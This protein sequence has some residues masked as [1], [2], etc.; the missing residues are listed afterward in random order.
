MSGEGIP[1]LQI[2][3]FFHAFYLMTFAM[4]FFDKIASEN[5]SLPFAAGPF[6]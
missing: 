3:D 5:Q 1:H 6:D 2:C 4:K